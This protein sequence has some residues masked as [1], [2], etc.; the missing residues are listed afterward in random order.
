MKKLSQVLLRRGCQN[1]IFTAA[2]VEAL[3]PVYPVCSLF[4]RGAR[5]LINPVRR[6]VEADPREPRRERNN[7]SG[8]FG[9]LVYRFVL[10]CIY[11]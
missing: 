1:I 4:D 7:C 6:K 3:K 9:I 10:M 2:E 8:V 11:K 5:R